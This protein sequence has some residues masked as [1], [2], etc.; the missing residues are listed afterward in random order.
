M[1]DKKLQNNIPPKKDWRLYLERKIPIFTVATFLDPY[2]QMLFC[3]TGFRFTHRMF[4]YARETCEWY[5][6][7]KETKRADQYYLDL[8]KR[9][10]K[11]FKEW[12]HLAHQHNRSADKLINKFSKKINIEEIKKNF[13]PILRQCQNTMLYGT[14]IPYRI[15]SA[16]NSIAINGAISKSYIKYYNLF[17]PLREETRYPQF[18]ATVFSKFWKYAAKLTKINDHRLFSCATPQEIAQVFS[19][20]YKMD[21]RIL[22]DR[23]QW[24]MFWSDKANKIHF[25]YKASVL[26]KIGITKF[27]S[28]KINKLKGHITYKGIIKGCVRIVN[29]IKDAKGFRRGDIIVSIN[30]NPSLMPV[31]TK[32]GGI[33]TDE[34][35]IMCHAAIMSR[36]FRKPCITGT[37]IATKVLK[38][39]DLVE[40]DANRGF[41]VVK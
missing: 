14:V 9:K 1:S 24:C 8:L 16:I 20:H 30:T 4:V 27:S 25:N 18:N 12:V 35:G 29:D 10:D 32:C 17:K 26:K 38:D 40:V 22:K 39:G 3:A 41:V 33:I 15:L 13:G 28:E 21:P 6:S 11:R 37:K 7:A 23:R 34:G 36:E 31:I 19:G 5:Y 2:G